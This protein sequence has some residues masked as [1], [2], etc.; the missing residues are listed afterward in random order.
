MPG[1]SYPWIIWKSAPRFEFAKK[2]TIYNLENKQEWLLPLPSEG[3]VDPK[4]NGNFVYW[5]GYS[6]EDQMS[7]T[8]YIYNILK[9][10]IYRL[11]PAENRWIT[12]VVIHGQM[13][14]WLR[15][16]NF[17]LADSDAYLEWGILDNSINE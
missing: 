7:S 3:N 6:S 12:D 16:E 5:T 15:I 4:I 1:F 8:L 10:T 9:Q 14:S 13:I 17:Q 11:P 2:I